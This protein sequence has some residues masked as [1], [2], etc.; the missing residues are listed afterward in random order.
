MGRP[1]LQTTHGVLNFVPIKFETLLEFRRREDADP[2]VLGRLF[3]AE[4][5]RHPLGVFSLPHTLF[6]KKFKNPIKHVCVVC[7]RAR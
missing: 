6:I 3:P 1:G 2:V 5:H 4:L 7:L